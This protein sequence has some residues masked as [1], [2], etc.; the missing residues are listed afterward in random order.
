MLR[1]ES[2]GEP[3]L[4]RDSRKLNRNLQDTRGVHL[5]RN[6]SELKW[7]VYDMAIRMRTMSCEGSS[8][9]IKHGIEIIFG[10][11]CEVNRIIRHIANGRIRARNLSSKDN[12]TWGL[13]I[14]V[15]WLFIART[16][17]LVQVVV[18]V[19]SHGLLIKRGRIRGQ[20]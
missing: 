19:V 12:Q 8:M 17:I 7:K 11:S 15:K 6:G 13:A 10:L 2:K 1:I 14:P 9:T 16:N 20:G 18:L 3:R 4:V 5:G